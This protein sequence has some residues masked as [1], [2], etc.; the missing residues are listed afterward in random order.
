[1]GNNYKYNND[2][3]RNANLY[4]AVT[5]CP[6]AVVTVQLKHARDECRLRS[7]L[8]MPTRKTSQPNLNVSPHSLATITTAFAIYYSNSARKMILILPSTVRAKA[9]LTWVPQ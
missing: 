8:P 3:N 4:G 6:I 5:I 9:E 7:R 1:M 2:N